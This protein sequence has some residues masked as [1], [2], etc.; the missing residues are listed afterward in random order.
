M[1]AYIPRIKPALNFFVKAVLICYP[2]AEP[3]ELR[4][5]IT[6]LIISI[7]KL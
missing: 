1:A 6:A 4:Y 2:H 3:F 7:S 5:I